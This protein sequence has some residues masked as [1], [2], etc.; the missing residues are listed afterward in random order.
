MLTPGN[1]RAISTSSSPLP[2]ESEESSADEDDEFSTTSQMS[3]SLLDAGD[4]T[5]TVD[6]EV[7]TSDS[8][9]GLAPPAVSEEPTYPLSH[10]KDQL[11]G[12]LLRQYIA[13][14]THAGESSAPNNTSKPEPKKNGEKSKQTVRGKKR[15]NE[16]VDDDDGDVS[17]DSGGRVPKKPKGLGEAT[18]G[19]RYFACPFFKKDPIK[20]SDC[21]RYRLSRI[22]DVKQHLRRHHSR[23]IYCP[24]C[25][26]NFR[27]EED[28]DIHVRSRVCQEVS[29]R[30]DRFTEAQQEKLS[31]KLPPNTSKEAQWLAMFAIVFPGHTP[32]ASAYID[33]ELSEETRLFQ[34]YITRVGPS[35]L[36]GRL[37]QQQPHIWDSRDESFLKELLGD[38]L[39]HLA[40]GWSRH[41]TLLEQ[42]GIAI[43]DEAAG[44]HGQ[45]QFE[46]PPRAPWAVEAFTNYLP[47]LSASKDWCDAQHVQSHF[48][49]VVSDIPL[50]GSA[51]ANDYTNEMGHQDSLEDL[52][53][54]L[55]TG[56]GSTGS[57]AE[58]PGECAFDLPSDNASA[59]EYF[60]GAD[61]SN[62]PA[63]YPQL[64]NT[65][66]T[67]AAFSSNADF[68]SISNSHWQ[69]SNA[70]STSTALFLDPRRL[71]G[72][73]SKVLRPIRAA[74]VQSEWEQSG[75]AEA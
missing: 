71:S 62:T 66:S 4:C 16:D 63:A 32:P 8:S 28:R 26:D 27:K 2:L 37:Q 41:R 56:L 40:A 54:T 3:S 65:Q 55:N 15:A 61:L 45:A 23:P 9:S 38:A 60:K 36:L 21:H 30:I 43:A 31:E 33:P 42:G 6:S 72:H 12:I 47:A 51:S 69:S 39:A 10:E 49:A 18:Q 73:S 50:S 22:R 1:T 70:D 68:L 53:L 57:H 34:D 29:F 17:S 48:Q 20:Y 67:L 46:T 25:G 75:I 24:I 5:D 13:Y 52:L 35:F 64:S 14:R 59:L 44:P 11:L 74:P 7:S 19:R 58:G